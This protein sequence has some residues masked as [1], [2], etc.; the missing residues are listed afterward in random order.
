[1]RRKSFIAGLVNGQ[2]KLPEELVKLKS[3]REFK[4]ELDKARLFVFGNDST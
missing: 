4:E 3:M 2:D 1:M